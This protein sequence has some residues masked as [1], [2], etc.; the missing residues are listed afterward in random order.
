MLLQRR[1][2]CHRGTGVRRR[3]AALRDSGVLTLLGV[4]GH[5]WFIDDGTAPAQGGH[6][7]GVVRPAGDG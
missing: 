7:R 5:S 4:D 6:G 1:V 2:A 3:R